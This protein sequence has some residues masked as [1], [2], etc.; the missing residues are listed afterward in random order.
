MDST[1]TQ[2]IF[3]IAL[4]RHREL[5]LVAGAY[6][7]SPISDDT[8]KIEKNVIVDSAV[9]HSDRITIDQSE[10]LRNVQEISEKSLLK[11]FGR[12]AKTFNE[13]L[14][15]V[16]NDENLNSYIRNYIDRRIC[17]AIEKAASANIPIFIRER[18]ANSLYKE[19]QVTFH[20]D[21]ASPIFRFELD[22]NGIKYSLKVQ[23]G[24]KILTLIPGNFELLTVEPC[25]IRVSNGI[26]KV[27]GIDGRKFVPYMTKEFVTIPQQSVQKYME[28]FVLNAVRNNSVEAIG[29]EVTE[30]KNRPKPILILDERLAGGA[31]L[32]LSFQYGN[33]LISANTPAVNEVKLSHRG[34]SYTFTRLT[35]NSEKEDKIRQQLTKVWHLNKVGENEYFPGNPANNEFD[36]YMVIEWLNSNY[37]LL[38]DEGFEIQQKFRQT[39]YFISDFELKLKLTESI[40]WFDLYGMVRIGEFDIPFVYFRKHIVKNIREYTLPNGQIFILPEEWFAKYRTVL[41]LGREDGKSIKLSKASAAIL[42]GSGL[43]TDSI[44][45]FTDKLKNITAKGI[46]LPTTLQATLRDYQTIGFAWLKTLVE[47]GLNG[48]LADDMGL[49]KTLQTI[50]LLLSELEAN[51][52]KTGEG[53]CSLVITPTSI[54]YN[55]Q[56]EFEKFAPRVKVG[57]YHGTQRDKSHKMFLQNHVV[58][59]SYGT[60]RNDIDIFK[61]FVFRYVVLDESQTIKNPASK[62]YRCVLLLKTKKNLCLSGTPIENNLFD[63]WSQMNFLNRGMLGGLK[64]F[65]E[66]FAIPIERKYDAEKQKQLKKLI[67]P[68]ILRRTKEQVAKEL[69]PITEQ[70]VYCEMTDEQSKAYEAEKSKARRLILDSLEQNKPDSTTINVL[71]AL[72]RL[73]QLA[74]HPA[75]LDEYPNLSSGKFEEVTQMIESVIAE[76][77]K[78]LI[79]SS[80]VKHL[81]QVEAYL[82][83]AG[84]GYEM[85]TGSTTDRSDVVEEFQNN[86]EKKI[87]LISLKAGGVGLN[88]TAADYIF[89]LDPWWNPAAEMQAASRA[90]RIGQTKSVFVYRFITRNTVEEKIVKLQAHKENLAHEFVNTNNPMI[91]LNKEQLISLV[92]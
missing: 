77:H 19:K 69:P 72:T 65:R 17:K 88:L 84:I 26:Y 10:I 37:K 35:R 73:R 33:K 67:E 30:Q 12:E 74:N 82:Q 61:D 60:I 87:F 68:L 28:T 9:I 80:F 44:S 36:H 16:Q 18:N 1:D 42:T 24:S 2:Y 89:I 54:M 8:Y 51:E 92:E 29:F 59:T 7:I 47:N 78:I 25:L 55:W 57:I 86:P 43:E 56:K 71:A 75:M 21:V 3:A 11:L 64:V 50:T 91:L 76:N 22:E 40:D 66:E 4:H 39:N 34:N 90:H 79:F 41:M 85:L 83:S 13:L 52:F 58:I 45:N 27:E 81:V 14:Q 6:L 70:I 15:K 49:G 63:L 46:S 53:Q 20:S 48:C 23:H 38:Q 5:G 62:I 32:T 31:C